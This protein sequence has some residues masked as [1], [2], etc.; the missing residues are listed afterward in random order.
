ML[1]WLGAALLRKALARRLELG[2][3]FACSCS[4]A[5]EHPG[6]QNPR[7]CA[8]KVRTSSCQPIWSTMVMAVHQLEPATA[9]L[10]SRE[11]PPCIGLHVAHETMGAKRAAVRTGHVAASIA[12][13]SKRHT[14][15]SK[16]RTPRASRRQSL[17]RRR[18]RVA[19]WRLGSTMQSA[20]NGSGRTM[21]A[22]RTCAASAR[23]TRRRSSP[24][25]DRRRSSIV[26]GR[27]H[28]WS[29][30]RLIWAHQILRRTP[31]C[32]GNS[33]KSLRHP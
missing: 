20:A 7:H 10:P 2:E 29:K 9:V 26:S 30:R 6:R 3:S 8:P 25:L 33:E 23:Q 19:W 1:A 31:A 15:A 28:K 12:E 27:F 5:I 4:L 24:Q 18:R 16:V 14:A 17:L 22:T 21:Q 13:T 11:T 32:P